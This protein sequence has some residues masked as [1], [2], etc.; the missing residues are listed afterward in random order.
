MISHQ[1]LHELMQA[2][3]SVRRFRP[4]LPARSLIE[5]V[6][7]S[8]VTAPSASN[9]QPWRFIVV[10][11]RATIAAMAASV[12]SA[13]DRIA[14][15]VE[16]AFEASFRAYGDYFTRFE[17]APVV[18][19]PICR[20]LTMLS[21][22]TGARLAEDDRHRILAMERDSGLIGTSL[23]LQNLLLAAQAAGLGASGMTGP[24]VAEDALRAALAVPPSWHLVALVPIGHPD[25][26]PEPTQR[27]SVDHVTRWIE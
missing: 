19:A 18:I 9:K 21:N 5:A 25:E 10:E 14:A 6:L 20:P 15:A 12:R 27:K 24:L 17:L 8:A 4:D 22:L 1:E 26:A 23:A 3:R 7:A 13:I 11:N 2:R 16:P